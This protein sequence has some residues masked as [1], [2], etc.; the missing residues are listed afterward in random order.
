MM[1][2]EQKSPFFPHQRSSLKE[3]QGKT[4]QEGQTELPFP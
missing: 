4:I 2:E 3:K 1:R